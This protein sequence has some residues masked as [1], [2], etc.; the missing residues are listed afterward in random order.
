M[1]TNMRIS[2]SSAKPQAAL[3]AFSEWRVVNPGSSFCT[4]TCP[5]RR[6]A[7]P[8]FFARAQNISPIDI[9][10][11]PMQ[12]HAQHI[13]QQR[14]PAKLFALKTF[15]S[16]TGNAPRLFSDG[17]TIAAKTFA[18]FVH[19]DDRGHA[20]IKVA[21]REVK[22]SFLGLFGDRL[23]HVLSCGS[24]VVVVVGCRSHIV[25]IVGLPLRDWRCP[26]CVRHGS[27]RLCWF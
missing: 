8:T 2:G 25:P 16:Q 10:A 19:G 21:R 12:F 24:I 26:S 11:T 4:P 15:I 23:A 13:R 20:L 1:K 3:A 14:L 9:R 7:R 5:I 22:C 6:V 18:I 17:S 27:H